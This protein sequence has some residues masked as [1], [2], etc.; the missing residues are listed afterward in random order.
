MSRICG[1]YDRIS[2]ILGAYELAKRSSPANTRIVLIIRV[3][4]A[5]RW[6]DKHQRDFAELALLGFFPDKGKKTAA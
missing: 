1:N 3:K 6:I 4:R 2:A 5:E